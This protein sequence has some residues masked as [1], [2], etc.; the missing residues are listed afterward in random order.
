MP[1]RLNVRAVVRA[2]PAAS[3]TFDVSAGRW[4]RG[5]CVPLA[6]L[7]HRADERL[8]PLHARVLRAQLGVQHPQLLGALVVVLLEHQPAPG[9]RPQLLEDRRRRARPAKADEHQL[10]GL[11]LGRHRAHAAGNRRGRTRAPQRPSGRRH[12]LGQERPLP[13]WVA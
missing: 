8:R 5:Q 13:G 11:D 7:L 1:S 3:L 9:P 10:C 6:A 2:I 12:D 4:Q